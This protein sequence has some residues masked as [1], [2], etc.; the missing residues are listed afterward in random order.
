MSEEPGEELS[1][2]RLEGEQELLPAHLRSNVQLV[3]GRVGTLYWLD[4]LV[5][6]RHWAPVLCYIRYVEKKGKALPTLECPNTKLRGKE[7][8]TIDVTAQIE[9]TFSAKGKS[10]VTP[11]FVQPDSEQECLGS[12]VVSASGVTLRL[13]SGS[14]PEV[15][16]V[17]LVQS[18]TIRSMKGCYVHTQVDAEQCK[19]QLFD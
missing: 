6:V 9:F 12:N 14:A 4:V 15:A 3:S 16:Q 5:E 2:H 13:L 19:G 11:V 10:I 8:H 18:T 1:R 17:S 7:G